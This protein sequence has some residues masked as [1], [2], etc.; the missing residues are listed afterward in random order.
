METHV[1]KFTYFR[2]ALTQAQRHG[3]LWSHIIHTT[4]TPL[5]TRTVLLN[6]VGGALLQDRHVCQDGHDLKERIEK[7]SKWAHL[8]QNMISTDS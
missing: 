2:V 8:S 1:H 6:D 7:L 3:V 4:G 5:Y